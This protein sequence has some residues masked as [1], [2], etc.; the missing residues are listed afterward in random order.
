MAPGASMATV[1]ITVLAAGRLSVT[2]TLVSV[3]LPALLTVPLYVMMPPGS[4]KLN[5]HTCVTVIA[6]VVVI[7]HVVLVEF[8]TAIPQ[9]LRPVTVDMLVLVQFVGAR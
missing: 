1:K 3:M 4:A 9:M 6:G 8:V 7:A 2:I 5:G